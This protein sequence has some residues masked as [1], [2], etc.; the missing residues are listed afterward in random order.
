MRSWYQKLSPIYAFVASFIIFAVACRPAE[1]QNYHYGL[2]QSMPSERHWWS[3]AGN[4]IAVPFKAAGGVTG[5]VPFRGHDR[6]Y[7]PI[8]RANVTPFGNGY[9]VWGGDVDGIVNVTPFGRGYTV[10]GGNQ[11]GITNVSRFGNGYTIWGNDVPG[12][13]NVTPFGNGETMWGAGV[14][15]ITNI[16]PF[17]DG[18]TVWGTEIDG[19]EN[20][21]PFGDGFTV[22]P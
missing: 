21:T 4:V 7:Q 17:G 14:D 2:P 5:F 8:S 6:N 16:T 15:G 19:I 9:T 11:S 1:A 22:W 13:I 3:G 18:Q 12:M 20:V 10:W